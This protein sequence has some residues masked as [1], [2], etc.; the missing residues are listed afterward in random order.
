MLT[1]I[2]SRAVRFRVVAQIALLASTAAT[3]WCNAQQVIPSDQVLCRAAVAS[4]M[5][6]DINT[7]EVTRTQA[8]IT[9]TAYIR[10]SD[11]SVWRNR[12]RVDGPRIHWGT[13]VGRWRDHPLDEVVTYEVRGSKLTV[14]VS[15][16]GSTGSSKVFDLQK[17]KK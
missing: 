9:F 8:N 12:C 14:R 2:E 1:Y 16:S 4:L 3:T 17:V 13:D 5:G 6:R 10:P 11:G 15:M 7:I